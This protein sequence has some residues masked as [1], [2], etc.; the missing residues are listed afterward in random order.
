[1]PAESV[2]LQF[3]SNRKDRET[4]KTEL[5]C[6]IPVNKTVLDAFHQ[7][8]KLRGVEL[9]PTARVFRKEIFQCG[10]KVP[11]RC[12]WFHFEKRLTFHSFK[13][14]YATILDIETNLKERDAMR[15]TRHT[16]PQMSRHYSHKKAVGLREAVLA[17][18]C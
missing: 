7:L 9:H 18:E 15:L 14:T 1:M 8:K 12:E 3:K 16:T 17:T 11:K 2:S 10:H 6:W 4:T 5:E 13:H